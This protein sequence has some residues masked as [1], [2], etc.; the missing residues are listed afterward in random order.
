[1]PYPIEKKLVITLAS[2]ALFD[3]ADS[4]KVYRDRLRAACLVC[5]RETGESGAYRFLRP[6]I[7][8]TKPPTTSGQLGKP[9]QRRNAAPSAIPAPS[10]IR[11]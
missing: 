10:A 3:L 2:S 5:D 7:A 8:M 9:L 6:R 1:M 4:D 11:K